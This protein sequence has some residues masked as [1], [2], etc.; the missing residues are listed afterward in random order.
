MN[1]TKYLILC[2]LML[3]V[4]CKKNDSPAPGVVPPKSINPVGTWSLVSFT[5]QVNTNSVS[6][7]AT[8]FPCLSDNKLLINVDGTVVGKYIGSDSCIVY[9]MGTTTFTLGIPGRDSTKGTWTQ[10]VNTIYTKINNQN[11]TG[12]ISTTTGVSQIIEKDTISSLN[13]VYT[14]VFKK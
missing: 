8:D 1:K 5:E 14:T 3:F 4:A 12:Q 10:S 2:F 13:A 7:S 11:T 6:Y 9:R